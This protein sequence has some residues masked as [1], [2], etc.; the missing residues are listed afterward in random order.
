MSTQCYVGTYRKYNNGSI[1]GKWMN[2]SD[3]STYSDFVNACKEVHKDERFPELMIQDW[4]NLPD[5]F[6]SVEWIWESDF[7]DLK[8]AIQ[9]EDKATT[10]IV[11]YSEKAFVVVGETKA[12]KEQLKELGGRFN[13]RLTCGAGWVFSKTK[14]QAVQE[15]LKCGELVQNEQPTNNDFAEL[16]AKYERLVA[17]NDF[18]LDYVMKKMSNLVM[19]ESGIIAVFEKPRM[20]VNFCWSDEGPD[21]ENYLYVH[22]SEERLKE[23]FLSENLSDYDEKIKDICDNEQIA[24]IENTGSGY[25]FVR[26][27]EPYY[28]HRHLEMV[29]G[30][31]ELVILTENDRK[32]ILAVLK[33][34]RAKFEKRLNTYLKKYGTSKLHTWTY[35]ADR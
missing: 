12:L 26:I 15:F 4:N 14:L 33:E 30:N 24:Y 7:N 22:K 32:K 2:L 23:Y 27:A 16:K 35:W 17:K 1:E 34:E 28:Y 20:E 19:T 6:P 31:N 10:R 8:A 9:D 25:G 11:D 29:R 3:Y 13:N 21:Y 5:G 18:D